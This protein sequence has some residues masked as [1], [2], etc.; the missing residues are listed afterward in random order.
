MYGVGMVLVIACHVI[1][2]ISAIH[3]ASYYSG[4][5]N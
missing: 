2:N 4:F 1:Y 3:E 5:S